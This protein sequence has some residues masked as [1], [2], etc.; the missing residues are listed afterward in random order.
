[1]IGLSPRGM[2][3]F[4]ADTGSAFRHLQTA[5]PLRPLTLRQRAIP[6]C[7]GLPMVRVGQAGAE[8][9]RALLTTLAGLSGRRSD[10]APRIPMSKCRPLPQITPATSSARGSRQRPPMTTIVPEGQRMRK[11][12]LLATGLRLLSATP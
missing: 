7:L 11:R 5:A 4:P 10:P 6:A 12:D 3:G 1:M 8:V 2:G 9:S